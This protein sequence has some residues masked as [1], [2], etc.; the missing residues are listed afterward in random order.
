MAVWPRGG[1][2]YLGHLPC[3]KEPSVSRTGVPRRTGSDQASGWGTLPV[4]RYNNRALFSVWNRDYL[5]P[6]PTE[7]AKDSASPPS[8]MGVPSSFLV[9]LRHQLRQHGFAN[10]D[11]INHAELVTTPRFL[12][13]A[14]N[15]VSFHFCYRRSVLAGDLRLS[16]P[17]PEIQQTLR[18]IVL[19]V[20]NTFGEKH[21]YIHELPVDSSTP[22]A[23][24]SKK[25][26]GTSC[27]T[28]SFTTDRLFHVSPFNNRLGQY[29]ISTCFDSPAY[30]AICITFFDQLNADRKFQLHDANDNA[31]V[32]DMLANDDG[33]YRKFMASVTGHG[34]RLDGWSLL[35]ILVGYPLTAFFTMPRI[36]YQAARL[37]YS[38]CLPVYPKPEPMPQS[39]G[40]LAPTPFEY[41]AILVVMDILSKMTAVRKPRSSAVAFTP[42]QIRIRLPCAQHHW[43]HIPPTSPEPTRTLT[44][45]C[46]SYRFFVDLLTSADPLTGLLESYTEG[47]W[48]SDDLRALL[49][50]MANYF[51]VISRI[52]TAN[53][54][55][56]PYPNQA[57][58]GASSDRLA[59]WFAIHRWLR[60][61]Q[62]IFPYSRTNFIAD[63]RQMFDELL[64]AEKGSPWGS[65]L[66]PS[67]EW[68]TYKGTSLEATTRQYRASLKSGIAIRL[69]LPAYDPLPGHSSVIDHYLLHIM[70]N[71]TSHMVPLNNVLAALGHTIPVTSLSSWSIAK[72]G[73]GRPHLA[74]TYWLIL[75]TF[76]S[77]LAQSLFRLIVRFAPDTNT[78]ETGQR[79]MLLWP[80]VMARWL[81]SY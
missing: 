63:I 30:L 73:F 18:F 3:V 2:T 19:E 21:L 66:V 74:Y 26:K 49:D 6:G 48:E 8:A 72:K 4:F 33:R 58:L 5:G 45:E 42:T 52:V 22:P 56:K 50:L 35:Y 38:R 34:Y 46:T 43:L 11:D 13:Y 36:V 12:G 16:N 68:A 41:R 10:V 71:L 44:V 23:Q 15:P 47:H 54:W 7:S 64:G 25:P 75:D 70:G 69:P 77:R 27:T 80:Q 61:H 20:N 81:K 60:S 51:G 29:R 79:L 65:L 17:S 24:G 57:Q 37:A 32:P 28:G 1:G 59:W 40:A 31:N 76:Q 67:H 9:K 55:A 62:T 39:I 53:H 78:Y 14:F